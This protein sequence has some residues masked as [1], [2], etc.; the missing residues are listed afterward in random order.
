MKRKFPV[1][2]FYLHSPLPSPPCRR[3]EHLP[4]SLLPLPSPLPFPPLPS[5][6]G[7]FKCQCR[8]G[9][10][11]HQDGFRCVGIPHVGFKEWLENNYMFSKLPLEQFGKGAL[12]QVSVVDADE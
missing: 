5:P 12:V 11:L 1:I 9:F 6:G 7:G 2:D 8:L 3:L 4:S 10:E